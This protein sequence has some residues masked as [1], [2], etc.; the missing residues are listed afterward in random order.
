MPEPPAPE[1]EEVVAVA[2][3]APQRQR[4][5]PT[6]APPPPQPPEPKCRGRPKAKAQAAPAPRALTPESPRTEKQRAWREYRE[7][8]ATAHAQR[9]DH[10]SSMLSRAL[11]CEIVKHPYALR[12]AT[13]VR[14][15]PA[16]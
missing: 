7:A 10:Y 5:E 11:C 4:K 1:P 15:N 12:L 2:R 8:N 14:N 6:P 9:R 13:A 16:K 3:A